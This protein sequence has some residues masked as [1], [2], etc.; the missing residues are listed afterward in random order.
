LKSRCRFLTLKDND[1]VE[2]LMQGNS[3]LGE[4]AAS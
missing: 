1:F 3:A 4:F 2:S